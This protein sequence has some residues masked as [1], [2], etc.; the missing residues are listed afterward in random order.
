[1]S[2]V[3]YEQTK[4]EAAL[5]SVEHS[6]ECLG[7]RIR[8][9]VNIL[10]NSRGPFNPVFHEYL[11][12]KGYSYEKSSCEGSSSPSDF[13]EEFFDIYTNDDDY[14]IGVTCESIFVMDKIGREM[15]TA[16]AINMLEKFFREDWSFKS[17]DDGYTKNVIKIRKI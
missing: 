13:L 9:I 15:G 2:S 1:M 5:Q 16:E 12:A 3:L 14:S 10:E 11:I 8:V 6:I 4:Q 17:R 7:A